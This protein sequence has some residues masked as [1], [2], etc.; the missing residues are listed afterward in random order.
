LNTPSNAA[1]LDGMRRC[2]GCD[3]SAESQWP[4]QAGGAPPCRLTV[5]PGPRMASGAI[6]LENQQRRL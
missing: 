4:S 1:A 2:Q 5:V 6:R 3:R